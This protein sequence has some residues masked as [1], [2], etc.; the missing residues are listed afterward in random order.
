MCERIYELERR[1]KTP[2]KYMFPY[3]EPLHWY[4]AEYILLYLKGN[5]IIF[6]HSFISCM[7]HYECIAPNVDIILQSELVLVVQR[8]S[9]GLMIERSL[10]RLPAGVLSS[11]LGQLSLPSLQGR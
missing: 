2:D 6:T 1:V 3:Y 4:T 9:V 7:H 5:F 10:V 11:H 8:F